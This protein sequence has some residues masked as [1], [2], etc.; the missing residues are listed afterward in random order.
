MNLSHPPVIRSWRSNLRLLGVGQLVYRK[1][2]DV[3]FDALATVL[4]EVGEHQFEFRLIGDGPDR[5]YLE[6]KA[7]KY[8]LGHLV[9]FDGWLQ[10]SEVSAAMR[11][12]RLEATV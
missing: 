10:P 7:R 9:T 5:Y 6:A 3:C 2:W 8:G 12:I 4:H 11:N 1:G